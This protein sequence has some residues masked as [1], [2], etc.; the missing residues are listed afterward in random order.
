FEYERQVVGSVG[1][2][3]RVHKGAAELSPPHG[4]QALGLEDAQSF[5]YRRP[6]DVEALGQLI[7]LGQTVTVLQAPV[8][9][10]LPARAGHELCQRRRRQFSSLSQCQ[11]FTAERS[12]AA[13]R[14]SLA[15]PALISSTVASSKGM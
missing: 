12:S 13:M 11:P 4:D 15:S 5:S 8:D 7:L 6:A 3:G 2:M 14:G 9:D 1:G 10:L